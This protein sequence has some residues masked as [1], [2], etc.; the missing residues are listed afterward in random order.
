VANGADHVLFVGSLSDDAAFERVLTELKRFAIDVAVAP[1]T[2]SS[3]FKFI[4][5]VGI[6]PNNA[7]RVLRRP[8]DDWGVFLKRGL[9][10]FGAGTG[11]ILLAPLFVLVAALIKLTSPGPVFYLQERRGFNGEIFPI[12]KFRSMRVTESGRAM[13]R[14]A[15]RND[16]RIT[17]VG[18]F[19]RA[20]SIDEL[21]Q[22]INVLLGEMSL[23]GPRPHAVSHDDALGRQVETYAHRQ[24][25]KP[26][27]TG[28]AQVNGFRGELT[29]LAQLEG[30]TRYDLFYID[31]RSIFLDCRILLLTVFSAKAHSNVF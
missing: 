7:V 8:I 17:P 29:T 25:I 14:Q 22:L 3:A 4:D 20:T 18:R 30:R 5:A 23:V 24:R 31:N 2:S 13:T 19:I 28:W 10:I 12:W 1:A 11:L 21:P 16:P 15:Q 26:G 9:D 6:G 27:I